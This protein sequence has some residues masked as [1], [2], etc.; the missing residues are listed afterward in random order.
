MIESAPMRNLS[1]VRRS[2]FTN[3]ICQYTNV[4]ITHRRSSLKPNLPSETTATEGTHTGTLIVLETV[5]T[6][7]MTLWMWMMMSSP[8]E[9]TV[10]GRRTGIETTSR[11]DEMIGIVT[12]AIGE[13][14]TVRGR[15]TRNET[16]ATEGIGI[17]RG[18]GN[19]AG[20]KVNIGS[21]S[22]GGCRLLRQ[23]PLGKIEMM[24]RLR[25]AKFKRTHELEPNMTIFEM[26]C[27][28]IEIPR[29]IYNYRLYR[30]QV[31]RHH[32]AFL[33]FFLS[34]L[35]LP[36]FPCLLLEILPNFLSSTRC[37]ARRVS[38]LAGNVSGSKY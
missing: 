38:L 30:Q 15:G 17:E 13:T 26:K 14:E 36:S 10:R 29:V 25:R 34:F 7:G 3:L 27:I 33:F 2:V 22:D 9:V 5:G 12:A 32:S 28:S 31:V 35:S 24:R 16:A 6:P 18:R 4:M 11:Q 37:N 19:M 21:I 1:S 20:S 23:R 8:V